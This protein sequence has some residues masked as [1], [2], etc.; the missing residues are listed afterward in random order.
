MMGLLIRGRLNCYSVVDPVSCIKRRYRSL[1]R[2]ADVG[3]GWRRRGRTR[4][5]KREKFVKITV[6][7]SGLNNSV[8]G[9]GKCNFF[10][11]EMKA[12]AEGQH[13]LNV[14]LGEILTVIVW[15]TS[16]G[17]CFPTPTLLHFWL[18][19]AHCWLISIQ[20]FYLSSI[21]CSQPTTPSQIT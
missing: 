9:R 8:C 21:T 6:A 10:N 12:T 18:V 20:L 2:A 13:A 16:A 19:S 1:E 5:I 17:D 3:D 14:E 4:M 11:A 15:W 7:E